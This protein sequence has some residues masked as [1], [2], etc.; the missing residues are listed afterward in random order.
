MLAVT[1]DSGHLYVQE[2]D[3]PK[4]EL[5]AESPLDFYSVN[6]SDECSFRLS[7]DGVAQSLVLH[8]GGKNVELKRVR[9]PS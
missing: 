2:N 3:E 4:R 1:L 8:L 9:E 7:N 6:S 5:L